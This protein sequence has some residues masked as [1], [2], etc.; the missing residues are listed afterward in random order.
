MWVWMRLLCGKGH[1]CKEHLIKGR[2]AAMQVGEYLTFGR[3]GAK[4]KTE[5]SLV[6]EQGR[7]SSARSGAGWASGSVLTS[8]RTQITSLL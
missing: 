7:M 1:V 2:G 6:R 8:L 3:G 4:T 5:W